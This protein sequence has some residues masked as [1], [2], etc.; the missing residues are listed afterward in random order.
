VEQPV[1]VRPVLGIDLGTTYSC[2]AHLDDAGRAVVVPNSESEFTSPSVVYYEEGGTAVV[3]RHA[4]SELRRHPDRVVQHI[5]RRMGEPDFSIEL[6]GRQFYPQQVSAAV[7]EYVVTEALTTLGSESDGRPL[8]D[9]VITVPAY[10]GSA[11]RE[12]TREAGE[13]AGLNVLR[14]INEPTAAA[15]AYG[16][17]GSG[18]R[19]RVLVYDL[20]GGT[21]D[22]TVMETSPS[23]IRAVATNGSQ[24]LGGAL[25]DAALRD[26]LLDAFREQHPDA[27]DP[28]TDEAALGDLD[29]VVEETKK[30]LTRRTRQEASFVAHNRR[31]TVEVTRETFEEHTADLVEQTLHYV[32]LVLAD[33]R[34]K[35]VDSL[36]EIILVGGMSRAPMIA[37]ALATRLAGKIPTVPQPRLVDPDQIVA[38]GAALFAASEVAENYAPD[39]P[40]RPRVP[41]LGTG[42]SGR[43]ELVDV[44]SRGYGVRAHRGRDDE[45]GYVAWIIQPQSELPANYTEQFRTL[46]H[47]QTT[48][49]IVVFESATPVL[50]EEPPANNELITG[51]LTGLPPDKPAGQPLEVTHALGSDGVLRIVATGPSGQ[52]LDL[53]YRLRGQLPP[54]ERAR[55]LPALKS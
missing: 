44:T 40:A 49:K 10:F 45:V 47:G 17:L 41:I 46:E 33:A 54:E 16:V 8:A 48:V 24:D 35:G 23:T 28:E 29:L 6:D 22:A 52:R 53:E 38:K 19:R 2:V 1:T 55:P 12:A 43:I 4:K 18:E 39:D 36:D 7:L 3:G 27:H 5:K 14:V 32:D 21:F 30:A 11:E 20:G 31:A 13:L 15:I 34:A 50:T 51:E 42:V 37:R 9:V 25:W 26:L